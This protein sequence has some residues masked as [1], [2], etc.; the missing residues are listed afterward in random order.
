[1][2]WS[3]G[4]QVLQKVYLWKLLR[5]EILCLRLVF[6]RCSFYR[7]CLTSVRI[8]LHFLSVFVK[9]F[10]CCFCL[11][12]E[13]T[14]ADSNLYAFLQMTSYVKIRWTLVVLF[15]FYFGRIV[16]RHCWR[17]DSGRQRFRHS[18]CQ[19]FCRQC[20]RHS[21]RQDFC[22]QSF[23]HSWRLDYCRAALL[24]MDA[25]NLS[26]LTD[27]DSCRTSPC[28]FRRIDFSCIFVVDF[29]CIVVFYL[30]PASPLLMHASTSGASFQLTSVAHN[31]LALLTLW[32]QSHRCFRLCG[33]LK[34][35]IF[36]A[37]DRASLSGVHIVRFM[38]MLWM[39]L[40]CLWFC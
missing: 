19:D 22:R 11:T 20:F 10:D 9:N 36:A 32:R 35:V 13:A 8:F 12:S 28:H 21:W 17:L 33:A 40:D 3:V 5:L 7:V 14:A 4:L 30:S 15:T 6:T 39:L 24:V 34:F 38:K 1:M 18:L 23:R 31:I 2:T 16:F 27:W 25:S 37:C 26:R 29:S